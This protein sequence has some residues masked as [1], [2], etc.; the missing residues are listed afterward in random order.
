MVFEVRKFI[1]SALRDQ[2]LVI[3]EARTLIQNSQRAVN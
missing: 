3:S 1:S 2:N